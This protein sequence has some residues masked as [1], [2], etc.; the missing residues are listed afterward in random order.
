MKNK[1]KW[2]IIFTGYTIM[3]SLTI[4]GYYVFLATYFNGYKMILFIN[5][6]GEA[7]FELILIPLLLGVCAIGWFY[8]IKFRKWILEREDKK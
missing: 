3:F 6:F 2:W 5:R 7:N 8:L 4:W 1:N